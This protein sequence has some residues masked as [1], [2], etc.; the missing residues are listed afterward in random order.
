MCLSGDMQRPQGRVW[1]TCLGGSRKAASSKSRWT[2][3][4]P[5]LRLGLTMLGTGILGAC[6]GWTRSHLKVL[7]REGMWPVWQLWQAS[8]VG[9]K[10]GAWYK[11]WEFA[12]SRK[13][14]P[15]IRL[16]FLEGKQVKMSKPSQRTWR[17]QRGI[18]EIMQPLWKMRRSKGT[19]AHSELRRGGCNWLRKAQ[20]WPPP[21]TGAGKGYTTPKEIPKLPFCW[22]A[23][24]RATLRR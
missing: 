9:G 4:R 8:R 16:L 17:V 1:W 6:G 11:G 10:H 5:G 21:S 12:C 18:M 24:Q 14:Q 15:R 3:E 20:A 22:L 23:V 13:L 19:R 7:S 2:E